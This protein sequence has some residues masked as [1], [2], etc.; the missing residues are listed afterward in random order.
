MIEPFLRLLRELGLSVEVKKVP[1]AEALRMIDSREADFWGL[2]SLTEEKNS[3]YHIVGPVYGS[4]TEFVTR[5]AAPLGSVIALRGKKIGVLTG[6]EISDSVLSYLYPEGMALFFPS[7]TEMADALENGAIDCFLTADN[8]D[9][10]ILKRET[11]CYEFADQDSRSDQGF[12]TM[13]DELLPLVGILD[14]YLKSGSKDM[15]EAIDKARRKG[16]IQSARERMSEDIAAAGARYGEVRVFDSG[17]LYPFSFLENGERTGFLSEIN[18]IF[19]ELSGLTVVIEDLDYSQNGISSAIDMLNSGSVHFVSGMYVN[20]GIDDRD[21]VYS[22]PIWVDNIRRYAYKL[23]E[24]PP[25]RVGMTKNEKSYVG[26]VANHGEPILFP[27]RSS[28]MDALEVGGVDAV[29]AS[30]MLYNYYYVVLNR[31]DLMETSDADVPVEVRMIGSAWNAELNR[32]FDEAITLHQV[33]YPH[34]RGDWKHRSESHR[35]DHVKL[36]ETQRDI[37]Y[38]VTVIF[39]V[40]TAII[41]ISL[42]RYVKYDRQISLLIRKQKT[43]DLVWGNLKDG[44]YLSKGDHQ[45]FRNWGFDLAGPRCTIDDMSRILGCDL[46]ED[47]EAELRGMKKS[48]SD[49]TVSQKSVVSPKD[50]RKMYYRRYMHYLN[51]YEFMECLQD[52]TDEVNKVA[53]LSTVASTDYLSALLTRRAMNEKLLQKSAD[54][55]KSGGRAFL[56]MYDIDDFKKVNDSYGHDAGDE[57]LKNVS[58]IIKSWGKCVEFTSR[59][60]GEEF[61]ALM[62]CENLEQAAETAE[63]IIEAV[64]ASEV[65][66]DGT[67][68]KINVTISGGL[69]ELD[70]YK[71]YNAS[72]QLADKALYDAKRSGKNRVCVRNVNLRMSAMGTTDEF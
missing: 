3:K 55:Q 29:F 16:L 11:L 28:L 17:E 27:T 23:S 41:L 46:R 51:E 57:V 72:V 15:A 62:V 14:R 19:E 69:V 53:I 63:R 42:N 5:R 22:A 13:K 1:P 25:M 34:S 12:V 18:Q 58:S 4:Y 44:S 37:L 71:H 38:S 7:I 36:R 26:W 67:S 2:I 8:A 6:S 21:L 49:M 68:K 48:G 59:W 54:M 70:P 31:Y 24:T 65:G 45:L 60:G 35:Y 32:L 9:V 66:I 64:E 52:V 40:M 20:T 10:E 61:L 39:L 47:F 33:I 56:V 50:A 43:F 30:E